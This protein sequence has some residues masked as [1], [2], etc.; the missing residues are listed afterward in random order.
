MVNQKLLQPQ[1]IEV[2]YILP[3]IRRELAIAMKELNL[4]QKNIAEILGISPAAISNYI[5]EKRAKWIKFD[6]EV[7]EQISKAAKEII[8]DK[9]Q[10][11]PQIQN[12]LNSVWAKRIICD[13][14]R[15]HCNISA[16]CE[17]CFQK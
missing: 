10:V 14:H 11:I 16:D 5:R 1:E 17:V 2:W 6:K 12:L 13:I 9:K 7:K 8:K 4:E 3:A 15:E